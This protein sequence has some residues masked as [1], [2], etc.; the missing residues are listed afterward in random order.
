MKMRYTCTSWTSDDFPK[1]H[2]ELL[3]S[4]QGMDESALLIA[5]IGMSKSL[6]RNDS[7]TEVLERGR[8]PQNIF[9][10]FV[11]IPRAT[12]SSI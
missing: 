5:R 8:E 2:L 12:H 6:F 4:L 7:Q 11:F 9:R 3:L 10:A 1:S